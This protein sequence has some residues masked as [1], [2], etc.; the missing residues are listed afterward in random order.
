MAWLRKQFNSSATL[1]YIQT[2]VNVTL[3]NFLQIRK[4]NRLKKSHQPTK[5]STG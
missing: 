2:L 4:I 5:R 1:N 3:K